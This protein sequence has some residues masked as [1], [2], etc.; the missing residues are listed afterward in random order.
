MSARPGSPRT[1]REFREPLTGPD[2]AR[3]EAEVEDVPLDEL[4]GY[5]KGWQQL[6]HLRTA[7][8]TGHA[9]RTAF[10][11]PGTLFPTEPSVRIP[12]AELRRVLD[13]LVRRAEAQASEGRIA[14]ADP[15]WSVP[16]AEAA[17]LYGGPPQLTLGMTSEAWEQ[18]RRMAEDESRTVGYGFVWLGDVLRAVGAEVV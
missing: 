10:D 14:V 12:L 8:E 9:L 3:F 5:L 16:T 7:P 2:L 17:D 1:I 18:L 4:E 13:V 15:Y 6:L 11:R